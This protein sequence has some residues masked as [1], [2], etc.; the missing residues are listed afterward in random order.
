MPP[1][2]RSSGEGTA[3]PRAPPRRGG[4]LGPTHGRGET[5]SRPGDDEPR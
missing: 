1:A 5:V 2:R 3:S 4:S